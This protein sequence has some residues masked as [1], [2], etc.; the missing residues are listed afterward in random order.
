MT[1]TFD[2][3][4][5]AHSCPYSLPTAVPTAIYIFIHFI[6][7][8]LRSHLLWPPVPPHITQLKNVTAVEG[9]AAM[10]SCVADG[11]PLPD[12]SW[13]RASDGQTFVDGDKV[14]STSAFLHH[15]LLLAQ[16]DYR[17]IKKNLDENNIEKNTL[18]WAV[19]SISLVS[20]WETYKTFGNME[21]KKWKQSLAC[22]LT[23]SEN[24]ILTD[25]V[26]IHALCDNRGKLVVPLRN[27]STQVT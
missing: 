15:H 6:P 21:T 12:I 1:P 16:A 11:E 8:P 18:L 10:I 3:V 13:K 25:V 26:S 7:S 5:P 4:A 14:K 9:G 20:V 19:M 22:I 27:T 17:H 2:S 23:W 24:D